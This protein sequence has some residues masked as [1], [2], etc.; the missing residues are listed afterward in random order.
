MYPATNRFALG[1]PSS[2]SGLTTSSSGGGTAGIATLGYNV[3]RDRKR[4]GERQVHTLTKQQDL[5][6]KTSI[7]IGIKDGPEQAPRDNRETNGPDTK[8]YHRH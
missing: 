4:A 3:R 8:H 7:L 2:S 1:R 5:V 6:S